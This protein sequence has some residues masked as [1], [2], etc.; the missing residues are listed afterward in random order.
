VGADPRTERNVTQ[1][2]PTPPNPASEDEIQHVDAPPRLQD[3]FRS[4]PDV[5]T[6]QLG[7]PAATL[8]LAIPED[9]LLKMQV[10]PTSIP[11]SVELGT[12][13]EAAIDK[14][15]L[16]GVYEEYDPA[17]HKGPLIY[18]NVFLRTEATKDR[19][20]HDL[21]KYNRSVPNRYI[22]EDSDL[23]GLDC[24][25]QKMGRMTGPYMITLDVLLGYN[26]TEITLPD[27]AKLAFVDRKRTLVCARAPF[28]LAISGSKFLHIC[29]R[30]LRDLAESDPPA[31]IRH[32]D[33]ICARHLCDT[34][35]DANVQ[36]WTTLLLRLRNARIRIKPSK[37]HAY[38]RFIAFVG[39]HMTSLQDGSIRVHPQ[40]KNLEFLNGCSP[41]KVASALKSWLA[42]LN[43]IRQFFPW[44]GQ[45]HKAGSYLAQEII[46]WLNSLEDQCSKGTKRELRKRPVCVPQWLEKNQQIAQALNPTVLPD[47]A[48]PIHMCFVTPPK[49]GVGGYLAQE[50]M[51]MNLPESSSGSTANFAAVN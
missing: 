48:S 14:A 9:E 39:L 21:K 22:G 26:Q 36:W 17:I 32:V 12:R 29:K 45:E 40:P 20:V 35:T 2:T 18:H 28:G 27:R 47:F 25:M 30:A 43:W 19:L 38:K 10:T 4:Y 23:Q 50:S 42:R 13:R 1:V 46:D 24:L 5:I 15:L 7:P 11:L 34:R 51:M 49:T 3:L 37:I 44:M 41:P 31:H 33:D 16:L 6:S 8:H